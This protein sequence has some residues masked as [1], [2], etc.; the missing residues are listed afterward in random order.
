MKYR[1]YR[2]VAEYDPRDEIF[3]GHIADVERAITFEA[4]TAQNVVREFRKEVDRYIEAMQ[5]CEEVPETPRPFA[6]GAQAASADPVP[7]EAGSVDPATVAPTPRR[8]RRRRRRRRRMR[9]SLQHSP[10]SL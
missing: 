10:T 9:K 7:A 3:Y 4:V 8:S 6:P 5:A 2:G 1:G